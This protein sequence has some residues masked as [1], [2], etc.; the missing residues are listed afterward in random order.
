MK[1]ENT[2][3]LLYDFGLR[4]R[5]VETESSKNLPDRPPSWSLANT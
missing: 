3:Y 1:L 5:N 4:N 2:T